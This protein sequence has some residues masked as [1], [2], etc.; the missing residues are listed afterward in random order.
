MTGLMGCIS[1]GS[2]PSSF[3][4][5][6]YASQA[7][8]H[9]GNT[10]SSRL[11]SILTP[12]ISGY[13]V[14]CENCHKPSVYADENALRHQ[15]EAVAIRR[16]LQ[17]LRFSPQ[18]SSSTTSEPSETPVPNCQWCEGT[19]RPA[20]LCCDVCNFFYCTP[21]QTVLHPSRG[22]LKDHLFVP[23]TSR[24][25]GPLD[26][27]EKDVKCERHLDEVLTMYCTVCKTPVCCHCIQEIRHTGHE[28]QSLVTAVK[29]QK[30]SYP[31]PSWAFI[32]RLIALS[33][34]R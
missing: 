16:I 17:R 6:I 13:T 3:V 5:S 28:M 8:P 1:F 31:Y 22:P 34:Y 23:A 20:D 33:K 4:G 30:V 10:S 27:A 24:R 11:P 29:G 26:D 12:S 15:P 25:L 2:R 32:S 7:I 14:N 21:C 19:P 9:G 18:P